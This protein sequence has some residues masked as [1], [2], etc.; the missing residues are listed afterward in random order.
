MEKL[1]L[2]P[3]I[4]NLLLAITLCSFSILTKYNLYKPFSTDKSMKALPTF[5]HSEEFF[6]IR[7][8]LSLFRSFN[9]LGKDS[10]SVTFLLNYLNFY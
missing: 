9:L 1:S 10:E 6:S 2:E 7:I 4:S 3:S 8:T 5:S